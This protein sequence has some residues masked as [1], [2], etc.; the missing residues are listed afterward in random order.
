VEILEGIR[1]GLTILLLVQQNRIFVRTNEIMLRQYEHD[2]GTRVE[3]HPDR[4]R[5]GRIKE[6]V[7]T[8]WPSIAIVGLIGGTWGASHLPKT[9][10]DALRFKTEVVSVSSIPSAAFPRMPQWDEALGLETRFR[11]IPS[12]CHL[13]ISGPRSVLRLREGL[14]TIAG[15]AK[16]GGTP[17]EIVDSEQDAKGEVS[18]VD[19]PPTAVANPG[20]TIR[21]AEDYKAG[22]QFHDEMESLGSFIVRSGHKIPST[23]PPDTIWIEIGSGSPWKDQNPVA[24]GGNV[25]SN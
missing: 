4:P 25:N 14:V 12:P 20:L 9:L 24:F 2:S 16:S 1:D 13:K 6:F 10:Q 3:G 19:A 7:R 17:C 8:Y 21:W 15:I 22:K 18:D 5:P 23:Y 11:D